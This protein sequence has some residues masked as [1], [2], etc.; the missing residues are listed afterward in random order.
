MQFICDRGLVCIIF[1][2]VSPSTRSSL[3][4]LVY[5]DIQVMPYLRCLCAL[6]ASSHE[7]I[8]ELAAG[9]IANI[10]RRCL[11]VSVSPPPPQSSTERRFDHKHH[12]KECLCASV[13]ET[14]PKSVLTGTSTSN[15]ISRQLIV[16]VIE[17]PPK[18]VLR[19]DSIA[20]MP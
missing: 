11:A 15:M 17:P 7:G 19:C 20:N 10:V 14:P 12:L 8:Q 13:S 5:F 6:L 16:R 2:K 4:V 1:C 3:S 9:S 18:S